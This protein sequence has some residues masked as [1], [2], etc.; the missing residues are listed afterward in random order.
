MFIAVAELQW[1]HIK[2][3]QKNNI[4]TCTHFTSGDKDGKGREIQRNLGINKT[5]SIRTNTKETAKAH[6][7]QLVY[8]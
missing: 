1:I 8:M 6:Q 5:E 2:M 3:S 4:K 7:T